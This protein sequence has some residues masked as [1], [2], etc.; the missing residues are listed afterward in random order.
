MIAE[1][2]QVPVPDVNQP[3][4]NDNKPL[5]RQVITIGAAGSMESLQFKG[6]GVDLRK[7]GHASIQRISDIVWHEA[8]QLWTV[9]PKQGKLAGKPIMSDTLIDVYHGD[10]QAL[11]DVILACSLEGLPLVSFVEY[12]QAVEFEVDFIQRCK[13][14]GMADLVYNDLS[15]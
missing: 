7:Y 13:L 9:V 12:E 15:K 4:S 10:T 5:S 6:K 3:P 2:Q 11:G 1:K 14:K 8:L